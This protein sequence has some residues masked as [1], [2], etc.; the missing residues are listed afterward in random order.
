MKLDEN[1]LESV[2]KEILIQSSEGEFQF[3]FDSLK[4]IRKEDDYGGYYEKRK[5]IL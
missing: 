1:H 4:P 5:W 3:V 2:I